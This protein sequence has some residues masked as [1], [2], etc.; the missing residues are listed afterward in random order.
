[1]ADLS[2]SL[3][4]RAIS[5][6]GCLGSCAPHVSQE[7]L[8]WELGC[9]SAHTRR[10]AQ[11]H[12][13]LSPPQQLRRAVS[14]RARTARGLLEQRRAAAPLA[15]TTTPLPLPVLRHSP[16][17]Q[18]PCAHRRHGDLLEQHHAPAPVAR[19]QVPPIPVKLHR[20]DDVR[21]AAARRQSAQRA[22]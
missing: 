14:W 11:R 2:I 7:V 6:A 3:G 21:C 17:H 4:F 8:Q 9:A 15:C 18:G 1:M 22:A 12:T 16:L 19:R 13:P 20:R 10:L 5:V